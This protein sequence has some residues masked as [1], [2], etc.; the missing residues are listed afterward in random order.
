MNGVGLA[1]MHLVW[2]HQADADVMVILVVPGEEAAAE[3]PGILD[4]AEPFGELRLVFQGF[5]MRL[6]EGV[7]VRGM[8][9]AMRLGDPE[10]G[11]QEGGCLGLHGAAAIGMQRQLAR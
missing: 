9:P 10:V 3:G 1:V 5:E 2:G 4:A 7:V 8:R 11:Q 6:R